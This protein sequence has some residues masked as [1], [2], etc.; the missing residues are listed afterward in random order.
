MMKILKKMLS[1][2]RKS[3]MAV[4]KEKEEETNCSVMGKIQCLH[5]QGR[6]MFVNIAPWNEMK[7][8]VY[9]FMTTNPLLQ[10]QLMLAELSKR[11][12]AVESLAPVL[13][14]RGFPRNGGE[15]RRLH[16]LSK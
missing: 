5:T 2:F 15:L 12:V 4:P 8:D 14:T 11:V 7:K 6:T 1:S 9:R 13:P 16:V 10:S 3:W